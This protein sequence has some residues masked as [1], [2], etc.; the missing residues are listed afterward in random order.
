MTGHQLRILSRRAHG[1]VHAFA[2]P[3]AIGHGLINDVVL[4][5]ASTQGLSAT[6]TPLGDGMARLDV[7]SGTIML[8]GAAI[9]PGTATLLPPY[10]PLIAGEL[11]FAWG[12]ADSPRWAEAEALLAGTDAG[13]A[14]PA[15]APRWQDRLAVRGQRLGRLA[16][17]TA[18]V[19]GVAAAGAVA[20]VPAG[21]YRPSPA[22]QRD[23]AAAA[24][25]R[26]GYTGLKV[27]S[28]PDGSVLVSGRIPG[29]ADRPA[30]TYALAEAGVPAT[31]A[32]RSG[33]ELARAAVDTA[34]VNGFA[35]TARPTRDGGIELHHPALT[36]DARAQLAALVRREVPGIGPLRL[37]ADRA[38]NAPPL[39]RIDDATK[40]VSSVVTGNPAY[41]VTADGAHY[42]TGAVLPSGHR[43]VAIRA[44][45]VILEQGGQQTSLRF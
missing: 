25:A 5:H 13:N 3:L 12:A 37:V 44:G 27:S 14:A 8:L 18:I 24:L 20:M 6:L 10:V 7:A 17:G 2:G 39:R 41:I 22:M 16:R 34:R 11:A 38:P 19:A 31:L 21:E 36:P 40:R 32:V 33:S 42:F 1:A 4:R 28:A 29:D 26:A 43:L 15:P 45:T 30:I 9:A 35:V 23:N